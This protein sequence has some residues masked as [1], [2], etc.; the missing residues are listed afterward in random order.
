MT[1]KNKEKTCSILDASQEPPKLANGPITRNMAKKIQA[2][3]NLWAQREVTRR[4]QDQASMLM[5]EELKESIKFI[6]LL[7]VIMENGEGEAKFEIHT[8]HIGGK[9]I[10]VFNWWDGP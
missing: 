1:S 6:N 10:W 9:R 2:R 7:E 4:I 8:R 3:L 5:E